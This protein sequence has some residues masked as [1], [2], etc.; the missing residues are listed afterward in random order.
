MDSF[1]VLYNTQITCMQH[2]VDK[3][4]HW[5][6]ARVKLLVL[7]DDATSIQSSKCEKI[8]KKLYLLVSVASAPL[9]VSVYLTFYHYPCALWVFLFYLVCFFSLHFFLSQ[10]PIFIII[11]IITRYVCT[12][13]NKYL[14][15]SHTFIGI[16]FEDGF[17]SDDMNVNGFNICFKLCALIPFHITYVHYIPPIVRDTTYGVFTLVQQ[18]RPTDEQ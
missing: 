5:T 2:Y 12:F 3:H 9:F 1:T 18:P 10:V 4:Q 14:Y 13:S 15:T 6:P 7:Y 8:Y 16:R 11:I 17:R